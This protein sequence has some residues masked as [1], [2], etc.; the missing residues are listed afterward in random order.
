MA[1]LCAKEVAVVDQARR[2]RVCVSCKSKWSNA[3][4]VSWTRQRCARCGSKRSRVAGA[5]RQAVYVKANPFN[6][7]PW[8]YDKDCVPL[9]KALKDMDDA[10]P[11]T[12]ASK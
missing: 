5:Q 2:V 9:E 7:K 4:G 12:M 8:P 11:V 1:Y 10:R 6:G 3:A